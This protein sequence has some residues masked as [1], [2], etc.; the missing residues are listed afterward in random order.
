MGF[1]I[2]VR[3]LFIGS[4]LWFQFYGNQM[5]GFL[6]SSVAKL[7]LVPAPTTVFGYTY[8]CIYALCWIKYECWAVCLQINV[9]LTCTGCSSCYKWLSAVK[10]K[11]NICTEKYPVTL[12]IIWL[13]PMPVGQP[14]RICLNYFLQTKHTKSCSYFMGYIVCLLTNMDAYNLDWFPSC[15][16]SV[17]LGR[18][19]HHYILCGMQIPD[20]IAKVM[21]LPREQRQCSGDVLLIWK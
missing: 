17:F 5:A 8:A 16:Q 4:G 9:V 11:E 7:R 21:S 2:S 14:W 20:Y 15:P 10:V 18:P 13:P 1:P 3:Y 19:W 6:I 12:L